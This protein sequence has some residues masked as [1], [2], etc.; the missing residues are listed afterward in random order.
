ME[1]FDWGWLDDISTS[2]TSDNGILAGQDAANDGANDDYQG[3]GLDDPDG[4]GGSSDSSDSSDSS[5]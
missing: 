1:I 4:S 3:D 2:S 5:S